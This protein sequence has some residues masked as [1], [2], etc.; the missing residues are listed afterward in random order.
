MGAHSRCTLV[1]TVA[2]NNDPVLEVRT[3]RNVFSWQPAVSI[4][5]PAYNVAEF[6]SETLD[7]VLAQKYT[8]Y[9]IIVVNDG[10]PDT[11][12]F[13]R[14]LHNYWENI[15]YIRQQSKGSA[16]AR[17]TAIKHSRGGLI[18]FLDA[19]DIWLPDFLASQVAFL[20]R[21]Y[22]MV[23]CDAYQFGMR[24]VLRK[25][26]MD[27]APSDGEVTAKSLLDYSCNVLTSSTVAKKEA[28][29]RAGSFENKRVKA[30]DFH[31]WIR[32]AKTGAKIGYQKKQLLKYRVHLASL[33]G[34]SVQRVEREINVFNRV[35]ED[36]ELTSEESAV[37]EKRLAALGA[38][39]HV[40]IGKTMLLNEDFASAY[41]E[42]AEANRQRRSFRLTIISWLARFAPKRLLR[43]YRTHR[44]DEIAFIPGQLPARK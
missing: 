20:G 16:P 12:Q 10:S 17:N 32:M 21:G 1:N 31:L 14:A 22:D 39:L 7:S 24:S 13:E 18:A 11:P 4:V 33:S 29:E 19:D 3:G 36:V 37:V 34:D 28:I 43:H 9:E 30:H 40:E 23:Y 5:I 26:F 38:D 6:I 42:F 35:K 44:A 27:T 41:R 25:T 2:S 8:D 15:I